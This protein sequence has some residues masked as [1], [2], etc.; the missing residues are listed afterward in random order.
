MEF[1]EIRI[2]WFFPKRPVE[3]LF[4]GWVELGRHKEFWCIADNKLQISF[5]VAIRSHY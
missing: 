4:Y 1:P 5:N 2:V 3:L